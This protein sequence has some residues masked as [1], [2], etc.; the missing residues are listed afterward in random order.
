MVDSLISPFMNYAVAF[1]LERAQCGFHRVF[2]CIW[3]NSNFI[4]NCQPRRNTSWIASKNDVFYLV[5]LTGYPAKRVGFVWMDRESSGQ[6]K[7]YVHARG[8]DL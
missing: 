1:S 2:K 3:H 8:Q 4:V 7:L 5:Q 6:N